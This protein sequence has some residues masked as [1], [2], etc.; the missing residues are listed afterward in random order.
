MT[1]RCQ[2]GLKIQIAV[3]VESN[4]VFW[5]GGKTVY[6]GGMM[7]PALQCENGSADCKMELRLV[8]P[9]GTQTW[10]SKESQ[11]SFGFIESFGG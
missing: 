2:I 11:R 7:L 8:L 1:S 10:H 5:P 3:L 9:P 6:S 4:Q